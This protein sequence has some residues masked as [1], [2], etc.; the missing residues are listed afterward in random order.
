[1]QSFKSFIRY[2][3]I[4]DLDEL[5]NS[6]KSIKTVKLKIFNYIFIFTSH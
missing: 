5:D 4:D 2:S 3:F 6:L 1:M